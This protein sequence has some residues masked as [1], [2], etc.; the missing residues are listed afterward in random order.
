MRR[1]QESGETAI[2]Q[3]VL[4][5]RRPCQRPR[6]Y[7]SESA[8]VAA[9]TAAPSSAQGDSLPSAASAPA[10]TIAGTAG[11]GRPACSIS[12]LANTKPTPYSAIAAPRSIMV[13]VLLAGAAAAPGLPPRSAAGRLGPAPCD[14]RDECTATSPPPNPRR[15][16]RR[17]TRRSSTRMR[18]GRQAADRR[19]VG[20]RGARRLGQR[21]EDPGPADARLPQAPLV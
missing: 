19:P 15:A 1:T 18:C 8:R 5:T 7:Q 10:T 16:D 12:T 17:V 9:A 11:T 14:A 3:T 20:N 21:L 13:P 6:L 4:S 2:L